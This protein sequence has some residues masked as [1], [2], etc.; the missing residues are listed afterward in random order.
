MSTHHT[1]ELSTMNLTSIREL[2]LEKC[3]INHQGIDDLTR[4][5]L[6]LLTK[7]ALST[8]PSMQMTTR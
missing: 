8:P 1:M 5:S 7:L 6:P 3:K 4:M 2:S